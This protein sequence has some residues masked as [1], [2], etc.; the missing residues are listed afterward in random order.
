[1]A[2]LNN[3]PTKQNTYTELAEAKQQVRMLRQEIADKEELAELSTAELELAQQREVELK[4]ETQR[5]RGQLLKARA[6]QDEIDELRTKAEQLHRAQQETTR[7]RER[8]SDFDF[9]KARVEELQKENSSLYDARAGLETEI[10]ANRIRL[11]GMGDQAEHNDRLRGQVQEL[12]EQN[13]ELHQSVQRLQEE[14]KRMKLDADQANMDESSDSLA[15]L[16]D[17]SIGSEIDGSHIPENIRLKNEIKRMTT[18][19]AAMLEQQ[20]QQRSAVSDLERQLNRIK[21]ENNRLQNQLVMEKTHSLDIEAFA[22]EQL[23][24]KDMAVILEQLRQKETNETL[25]IEQKVWEARLQDASEK[26]DQL[27]KDSVKVEADSRSQIEALQGEKAEMTKRYHGAK[28]AQDQEAL[29]RE[30]RLREVERKLRET[31]RTN[32]KLNIECEQRILDKEQHTR[33][34]QRR[35][36]LETEIDQLRRR[37]DHNQDVLEKRDKEIE[38]LERHVQNVS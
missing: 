22:K 25:E 19:N 6:D 4:E 8:L 11:S 27:E 17:H 33:T 38:K 26:I 24:G 1:M 3:S 5:V 32:E 35:L 10:A 30:E 28:R 21:D 23:E 36:Q 20:S 12:E 16:K 2:N 18:I 14:L 31:E 15:G 29:A 37:I 7:L 13:L 34:E 9:F